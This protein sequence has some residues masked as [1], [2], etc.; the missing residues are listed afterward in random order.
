MKDKNNT[1][2][3]YLQIIQ[4]HAAVIRGDKIFQNI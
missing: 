1:F 2:F 4:T 3:L